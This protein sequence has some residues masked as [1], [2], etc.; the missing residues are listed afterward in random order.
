MGD[1][2]NEAIDDWMKER[3]KPLIVAPLHQQRRLVAGRVGLAS[4]EYIHVFDANRLQGLQPDR[5]IYFGVDRMGR[6]LDPTAGKDWANIIE[7]MRGF[8][9]VEYVEI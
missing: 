9:N 8:T 6:A 4:N 5:K 2:S 3:D 1:T 7:A